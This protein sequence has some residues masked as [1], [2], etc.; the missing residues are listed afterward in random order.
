[1]TDAKTTRRWYIVVAMG[2][3]AGHLALGIGKA[4][5]ATLTVIPEEFGG[6]T[7][8]LATLVDTLVGAIIKRKLNGRE[9]GVAVIAEGA[10][11]SIDPADLVAAI[12]ARAAFDKKRRSMLAT[13]VIE[14]LGDTM[15]RLFPVETESDI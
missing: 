1:M 14:E 15:Q 9:D 10:A 3:S 4:A 6:K 12:A 8:P 5:G 7:V 13:D 11:L 2:R